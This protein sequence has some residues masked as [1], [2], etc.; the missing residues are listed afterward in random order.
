MLSY[1]NTVPSQR[2]PSPALSRQPFGWRVFRQ[3]GEN[4]ARFV[5]AYR[6]YCWPVES[7]ADYKLA[8]FHLLATEGRVH[9]DPDHLW[10]MEEIAKVCRADIENGKAN[11]RRDALSLLLFFT[12]TNTG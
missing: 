10:H 2:P 3:R 7:L 5:A 6:Q 1:L 12:S 11:L 9:A 4:V 8:P